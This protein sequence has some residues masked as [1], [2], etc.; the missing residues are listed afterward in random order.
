MPRR[1]SST[2]SSIS[3]RTG[4][5]SIGCCFGLRGL[6]SSRSVSET[7]RSRPI[8]D[9]SWET[10]A[11]SGA[12]ETLGPRLL[13]SFSEPLHLPLALAS[14]RLAPGGVRCNPHGQGVLSLASYGSCANRLH[15]V[16][17]QIDLSDRKGHR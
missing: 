12:I 7:P 14:Q 6:A 10:F 4:L 8:G 15:L 3:S 16:G 2:A 11:N 17:D 9:R 1:R 5:S 13:E